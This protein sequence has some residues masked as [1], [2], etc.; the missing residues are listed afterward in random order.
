MYAAD[1]DAYK[2]YGTTFVGWGGAHTAEQVRR[3]HRHGIR[4][5]G[6]MWCLTAGAKLLCENAELRKA[7]AVDIEGKPVAVPWLFDHVYNGQRAWFGCTNHPTFRELCRRRVRNVMA[8]RA[9]G[10]HVDDHAGTAGAVGFGGGFCD[11]CMAGFRE[12]LKANARPAELRAAGATDLQS[13]DYRKLVRRYASTRRQY[14]KVRDRIP[15]MKLF[16]RFQFEAAAAH[17]RNLGR[18]ACEV[19]GRKVLL[20]ANTFLAA[21]NQ[22]IVLDSITHAICEIPQGAEEGT[23]GIGTAIRCYAL[24][25]RRGKPLAATAAGHDW[26]FVK[27]KSCYDLVRFWIATAY[28]HGQRFMCPHPTRQWCFDPKTGTHWYAAPPAEFAPVYQFI[29]R[30]AACFDGLEAVRPAHINNPR[31]IRATV[32]RKGQAGRCVLHVINTDYDEKAKLM[33][34]RQNVRIALPKKLL[35]AGRKK[36]RLLAYDSPHC[37][38]DVRY[39]GAKAILVLPSLHLWTIC[40]LK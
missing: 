25:S 15:L 26:T 17:V 22:D 2:A 35:A 36:V 19:A 40:V 1:A 4:C 31:N 18:L 9:D 29:R 21:A 12:Y 10:L 24:A 39:R 20:S 16:V 30:N 32:R 14:L 37:S 6:M 27:K 13:F 38:A 23:G 5:T 7:C 34:P 3:H 33:R 28:A 8:G 11:H